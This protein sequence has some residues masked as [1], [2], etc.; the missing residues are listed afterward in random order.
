MKEYT[1]EKLNEIVRLNKLYNDTDGKEGKKA[2][3]EGSNLS[4]ADLSGADLSGANLE[5]A[6]L[7]NIKYNDDTIWPEGFDITKWRKE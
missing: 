5:D 1:K 2:D 7:T 4:G 6:D 3:L